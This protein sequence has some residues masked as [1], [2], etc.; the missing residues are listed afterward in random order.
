MKR[1]VA[2]LAAALALLVAGGHAAAQA[3][4]VQVRLDAATFAYAPDASL[5][6]VYLSFG[7]STL[8]YSTGTDGFEAVLPVAIE[9][10]P[11]ASAAPEAAAR[12]PV[13]EQDVTYRY[14][15]ADTLSLTDGQVFVEQVRTAVPPGEYELIVSVAPPGRSEVAV[16][17]DVLVPDYADGEGAALSSVQLARGIERSEDPSDPFAKSGLRVRPNPSA[18]YGEGAPAIAYYAEV[19]RP[20]ASGDEYTLLTYLAESDQAG[21]MAGHQR[22][23]TRSVRP[24]DVIAGQLDVSDVPSGIYYLRLVVLDAGNEAVAE[25]SKRVY[26]INPDIARAD[27]GV[28]EM[29]YEATLFAAM[30]EEELERGLRHVRVLASGREVAQIEALTSDDD[31][32]QF[33]ASFWRNRDTDGRPGVNEALRGFNERLALVNERYREGG[34]DGFDTERG[35]VYLKYGPPSEVDRR[36]FDSNANPHEVWTYEN[37]PGEGRSMFVFVDRYGAG[38][39]ELVYSDVTG[40]TSMANWRQALTR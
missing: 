33:L 19:Y 14:R 7:A 1:S 10:V 30:G 23:T 28:A 18:F 40:E 27:D 20:P 21:P 15:V 35:R 5:L 2:R 12:T 29:D 13:F 26:V 36:A 31:R 16:R 22:R 6:E 32:R 34:R 38:S 4:V 25:Q 39:Y 9:L 8:P 17:R 37:I 24:V 11:V 3:D